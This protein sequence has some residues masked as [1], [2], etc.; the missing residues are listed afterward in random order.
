MTWK[1]VR[2]KPMNARREAIEEKKGDCWRGN[3]YFPLE[4]LLGCFTLS[5]GV[6]LRLSALV[7]SKANCSHILQ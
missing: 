7:Y 5:V 6:V 1:F 3:N 2:P 4:T